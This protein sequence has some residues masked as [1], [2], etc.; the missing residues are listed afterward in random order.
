MNVDEAIETLEQ[1]GATMRCKELTGILE[2]LGFDVRDTKKQGH[3]VVTH[4]GLKQFFSFGFTCGHGKNP[5]VKR[6]Y[7]KTALKTLKT[8]RD[9]LRSVMEDRPK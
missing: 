3:K 7:V 4:A 1:A 2:S 5:E 8:Y 6:N 9:D